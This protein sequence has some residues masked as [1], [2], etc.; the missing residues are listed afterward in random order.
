MESSE[1]TTQFDELEPG[2]FA[3]CLPR[4]SK[5]GA[6][7]PLASEH[8]ELIPEDQWHALHLSMNKGRGLRD[9]VPCTLDQDR[10]GS[11]ATESTTMA[12][13][14]DRAFRGLAHVLLNP[15]FIYYHTGGQSDR[16]DGRTGGSSIDENLQFARKYGIAPMEVW[17]RAKGWRTKPSAAAYDA[18]KAF[19]IE[20]FFDIANY[21]E[22]ASALLRGFS[23]VYGARGHSVLKIAL[24]KDKNSWGEIWGDHGFGEWAPLKQIDF[25]YGAFA[26][27]TTRDA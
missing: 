12:A 18:A 26:V 15:W 22:A 2:R 13:M 8:I 9:Y 21:R 1:M 11:C 14:T 24:D 20:E 25:R 27:R 10:A 19:K 7:C 5:L 17:P 16:G 23:V 3:A 4:S 6:I